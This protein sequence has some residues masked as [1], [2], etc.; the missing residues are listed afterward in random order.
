MTMITATAPDVP[1]AELRCPE[2]GCGRFYDI[3][4]PDTLRCPSGHVMPRFKAPEAAAWQGYH[5]ERDPMHQAVGDEPAVETAAEVAELRAEIARLHA[6]LT[7]A[8]TQIATAP[9]QASDVSAERDTAWAVLQT[10]GS[11]GALRAA[12]VGWQIINDRLKHRGVRKIDGLEVDGAGYVTLYR[13]RLAAESGGNKNDAGA[14]P[15]LLRE[16]G[17][18]EERADPTDTRKYPR[19]QQRPAIDYRAGL[20]RLRDRCRRT[21]ERHVE[22]R[23]RPRREAGQSNSIPPCPK[24]ADHP[25]DAVCRIDQEIVQRDLAVTHP[26]Q[27]PQANN[28]RTLTKRRGEKNSPMRSDPPERGPTGRAFW[29]ALTGTAAGGDDG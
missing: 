9:T 4:G 27:A 28:I 3:I 13:A 23:G 21:N 24:G 16:L 10:K 8:R 2:P 6:E 5:N 14:G 7:A 22:K 20:E 11:G 18:I 25:I 19:F 26:H 17:C 12:L 29:E 15:R 1:L